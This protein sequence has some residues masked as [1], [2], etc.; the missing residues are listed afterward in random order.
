[1]FN[2]DS[3]EKSVSRSASTTSV[4]FNGFKE[5]LGS[6]ANPIAYAYATRGSKGY[7]LQLQA[8]SLVAMGIEDGILSKNAR[9]YNEVARICDK[10]RIYSVF[11]GSYLYCEL[12]PCDFYHMTNVLIATS[13]AFVSDVRPV[14]K[15]RDG[16][17]VTGPRFIACCDSLKLNQA[18]NSDLQVSCKI[19]IPWA[20]LPYSWDR[21]LTDP[22]QFVSLE[23]SGTFAILDPEKACTANTAK[24]LRSKVK[25]VRQEQA[26]P[27]ESDT[28]QAE[29]A[30]C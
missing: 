1:M 16:I 6:K 9:D 11:R 13:K 15:Y 19:N 3:A 27:A 8:G 24:G 22:V 5:V 12:V 30:T 25:Q 10:Y 23:L 29:Q 2:L 14:G 26:I 7:T 18:D 28:E 4:P 21:I 20:D 17:V